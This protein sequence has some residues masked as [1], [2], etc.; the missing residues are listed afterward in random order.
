MPTRVSV[1]IQASWG[2]YMG[3]PVQKRWLLTARPVPRPL[4]AAPA[5]RMVSG[6]AHKVVCNTAS[7]DMETER[8]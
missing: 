4:K 5:C 3:D 2:S 6:Q 1:L 7:E 8:Q